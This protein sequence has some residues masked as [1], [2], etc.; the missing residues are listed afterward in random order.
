MPFEEGN[1]MDIGI[2]FP[3]EQKLMAEEATRFRSLPAEQQVEQ[4]VDCLRLYHRLRRFTR[5]NPHVERLER[6]YEEA[7]H[8]AVLEMVAKYGG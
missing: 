5:D 1:A 6:E 2:K 7:G 8:R 4:I 3:D